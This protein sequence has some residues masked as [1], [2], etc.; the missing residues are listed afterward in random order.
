MPSAA[1]NTLFLMTDQH[2]VDTLPCYGNTIVRT[3]GLD[4]IAA[5]GTRFDRMYTPTAICTPAR[6]SLLTGLQPFRHGLLVNPERGHGQIELAD[7]VPTWSQT[8]ADAG[9]NVGHSGKWHVGRDR[10]PEHYAIEGE[11]MPGALNPFDFAPYLAWL[12]QKGLP[13]FGTR[14][15]MF[16]TAHNGTGRGHLFAARLTQP[17]EGTIE[18]Y[19]ADRALALLDRYAGEFKASGKPFVLTASW[20]GPH[21]PYLIPDEY[22]DMYDPAD[23]QLPASFAE[24]FVGK[25]AIQQRYSEYWGVDSFTPDQWRKLIAVYWGYVSMIDRAIVRLLDR[26]DGRGLWDNTNIVFTADHGEFTGAHRMHDKGPGMYEDIYRIPGLVRIPGQKPQVRS[27]LVSLIDL[28]T[29]LL[30]IGGVAD[31]M[32]TDGRSLV[33][34][35]CG[36]A[37]PDWR[38]EI[39][40]EFHGHHFPYAQ[41]MICDARYKLVVSPESINELYDL[42]EDPDE[43]LNLHEDPAYRAIRDA[44]AAR[45]YRELVERGDPTFSWLTYMAPIGDA[46]VGDVDGVADRVYQR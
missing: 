12:Q 34:L 25:P 31:A 24:Q 39:V 18:N 44:L 9:Y 32:P 21:L 19:I 33:P 7:T 43:L 6:A 41:R 46:R 10:G 20:F 23:V 17:F 30:D 16:S 45:L 27:E 5:S 11:H 15:A 8:L 3:P 38:T 28:T 14:E 4:R 35:V 37:V 22:Y 40:A 36:E 2:R 1:P 29:T 13:A 42:Q 26:L